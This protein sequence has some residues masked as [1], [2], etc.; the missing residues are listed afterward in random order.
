M[1]VDAEFKK[2]CQVWIDFLSDQ[3]S[4]G[5][6][7]PMINLAESVVATDIGFSSD[8]SAK[9]SLGFGCVLGDKWTY[10]MWEPGFI[11]TF[12]P[13]IEY[14][15][16]YA[17]VAG[18]MT[19]Q[20]ELCNIRMFVHCDNQAVVSMINNLSSSCP[21]CM[22]LIRMLVLNGLKYNR[23]IFAVYLSTKANYLVDSLS[24]GKI[25]K[26]L[27]LAPSTVNSYPDKVS[28][29]IWPPSRIWKKFN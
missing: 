14:L 1:R 18:I 23:R 9:A 22:I 2:D 8:A 5:V 24:R 16:L 25:R 3:S 15:E 19:W 4:T 6:C 20:Y 10:G 7:R 11:K 17:L 26:F 21:N 28:P 29:V 27:S 12:T 13:S